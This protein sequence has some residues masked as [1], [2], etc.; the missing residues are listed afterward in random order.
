MHRDHNIFLQALHALRRV[1]LTF[2]S[3]EDNQ[4]LVRLCAPMDYGPF[5]KEK[6][7]AD[8]YHLWDYESDEGPHNLALLPD[9]IVEIGATDEAFDPAEFVTWSVANSPWF[10]PRDWGAFS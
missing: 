4:E 5:R 1:R 10:V 7:K 6:V 8:R 2:Y 9:Q 3:K